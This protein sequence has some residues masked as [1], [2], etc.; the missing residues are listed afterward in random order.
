MHSGGG[1][2]DAELSTYFSMLP[3]RGGSGFMSVDYARDDRHLVGVLRRAGIGTYVM[4]P[5]SDRYFN[6][7]YYVSALKTAGAYFE[8]AFPPTLGGWHAKDIDFFAVAAERITMLPRPFVAHL[9]T[10]QSHGPF[11]NHGA[12][13][14]RGS[15]LEH[16]YLCSMREVDAALRSLFDRLAA[17]GVL[18]D[19]AVLVYG[20]HES[21][22]R[23]GERE[24]VPLFV[25]TPEGDA[26][27]IRTPVSQLDLAPTIAAMLG[28][29]ASPAWL[30]CDMRA[31]AADHRVIFN[32]GRSLRA[33]QG[34][35]IEERD[36]TSETAVDYS[37]AQLR[38]E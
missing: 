23:R 17:G 2:T 19:T 18:R 15:G 35:I 16:A 36:A 21:G 26:R 5:N 32:D 8:E 34:K 9:I 7:R 14:F 10:M 12:C 37:R 33:E 31:V 11:V 3:L 25:V 1:T 27:M 28:V 30:G 4:H 29:P 13:A 20:D 22:V 6:R 24:R 38:G